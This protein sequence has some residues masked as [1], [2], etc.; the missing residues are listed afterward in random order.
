MVNL[1]VKFEFLTLILL[2]VNRLQLEIILP[3]DSTHHSL[4]QSTIAGS[5]DLD[6]LSRN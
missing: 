4:H 6:S 3:A 5:V 2:V 1:I